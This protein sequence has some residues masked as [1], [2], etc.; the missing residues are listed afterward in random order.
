DY[1]LIPAPIVQGR[2]G[3]IGISPQ[4]AGLAL[5]L[6]PQA[7]RG[8]SDFAIG[9]AVRFRN[10]RADNIEDEV[11]KLAGEL[12]SAFEV[13]FAASYTLP[14]VFT[15]MDSLSFDLG[16]R[17]DVADAH[18]GMVIEP[19]IAWSRPIGRGTFQLISVNAEIVDDSFADYYYSV[20]PAQSAASDLTEFSADGGL[21][22]L[23]ATAFTAFDLDGNA[24]NGGFSI[25][26]ISG[27]SRL[28]GGSADT[29]YTAPRGDPN[30]FFIAIGVGYTF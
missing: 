1:T 15:R 20:S 19:R 21:N 6:T 7:A 11:V 24:L 30:Q 27:Y 25:V 4:P 2:L 28:V 12:E 9:P 10:D 16:A 18:D 22:S 14:G 23:G 13:G 29:P 3:G 26:S 17:W 5:D 8:Q